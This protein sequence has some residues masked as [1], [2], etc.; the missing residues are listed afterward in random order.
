MCVIVIIAILIIAT[1]AINIIAI[2]IVATEAFKAAGGFD[3]T[4][5]TFES[6][7]KMLEPLQDIV[8]VPML[9]LGIKAPET[10]KIE[11][12]KRNGKNQGRILM[13]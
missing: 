6:Y 2:V 10:F 13:L 9:I 7:K 3:N 11:V 1:V 12:Y 5:G 8:K 4:V